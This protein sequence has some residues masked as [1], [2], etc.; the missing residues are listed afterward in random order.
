[1]KVS[2]R[3]IEW[4]ALYRRLAIKD[5]RIKFETYRNGNYRRED[6]TE[7]LTSVR[8]DIDY[9]EKQLKY[10]KYIK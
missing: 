5:T 8:H 3:D 6:S 9:Y 4:I 2:K 7:L 10:I 1:M